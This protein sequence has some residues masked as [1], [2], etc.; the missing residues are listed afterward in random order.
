MELFGLDAPLAGLG[1]IAGAFALFAGL[2]L[3]RPFR[4]FA[5]PRRSRWTTNLVLYAVDTLAVRLLLPLAMVGAAVWAQD[6]GWGLF[7]MTGLPLWAEF[8][9]A[10]LLLDLALYIQHRATHEIPLLWRLHKVHH[11]DTGFDVTTAARF[12]PVEIVL[13][14][15]Y[16]M[17][18]VV[19]L[20]AAPL[21]VFVFEIG[22]AVATLFTH[23]NFALATP[24]ERLWRSVFVTPDM[25][26]IH[27]SA[28]MRET[29]SNYGTFLSG[30][31]RLLGTYVDAP[32]KG[33]DGFTIGLA[34]YQDERPGKLGWSLALPFARKP[35]GDE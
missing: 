17:A 26:R 23:S 6:A 24:L 9:L 2:E 11:T 33:Q 32:D 14:M 1:I 5:L 15:A 20:G 3:A 29:N 19:L 30:W 7:N 8:I 28:K 27:H 31:D 22:F 34:S 25:H 16:K 18:I 21:A 12:H 4:R 10:I 13:S 35:E